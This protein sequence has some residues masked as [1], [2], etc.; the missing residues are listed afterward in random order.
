MSVQSRSHAVSRILHASGLMQKVD[1]EEFSGRLDEFRHKE[2]V[3]V[4]G[5]VRRWPATKEWTWE[6]L[7]DPEGHEQNRLWQVCGK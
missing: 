4:R 5:L 1:V 2:P 6:Q 7:A 3:V